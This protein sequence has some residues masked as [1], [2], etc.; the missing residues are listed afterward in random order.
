MISTA[1]SEN[2]TQVHNMCKPNSSVPSLGV[3]VQDGSCILF[4]GLVVPVFRIPLPFGNGK[5]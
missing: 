2:Y 3:P 1:K 4:A 5:F